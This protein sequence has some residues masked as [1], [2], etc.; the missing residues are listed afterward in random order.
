M[1]IELRKRVF[2][3][4]VEDISGTLLTTLPLRK[5]L[6]D[7]VLIPENIEESRLID[8]VSA[9]IPSKVVGKIDLTDGYGP[10]YIL[11]RSAIVNEELPDNLKI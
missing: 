8:K 7:L 1:K 6:V 9:I 2:L 4:K 11:L 10:H 5:E 3:T